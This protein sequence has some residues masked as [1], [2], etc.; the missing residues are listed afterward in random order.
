[1]PRFTTFVAALG[2][3]FAAPA[4]AQTPEPRS[5]WSVPACDHACL[6][7]YLHRY[8]D[9]LVKKAPAEAPLAK[10]AVFTENDVAM[11][12]GQGL[13]RTISGASDKGLE[14]AD[15]YTGE[16]AWF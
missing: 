1:M 5:A 14:V 8:M 7:S 11:P 10:G 3:L 13:W 9:A 2:L 16:A 6:I 15:P 12:I 4:W